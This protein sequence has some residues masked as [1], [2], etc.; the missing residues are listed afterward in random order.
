[1]G[2]FAKMQAET[3]VSRQNLLA[4]PLIGKA[5]KGQISL[6]EY[7]AFLIE[8][9]HH[10]KHTVPLLMAAGARLPESYEWLREAVAE[11]IEEELGHQEWILNDIAA[12]GG[13]KEA[14]RKSQPSIATELMVAYAYDTVMRRSPLGFF[15]MVHVLEGTSITT[16]DA[17]AEAIQ[18]T[19][20]LPSQAFSYLKS[21]GA[22]DQQHVKFFEDLMNRIT[23]PVDQ[24][25]I[26]HSAKVFY[27]LYG[28]IFR[29][30]TIYEKV[31]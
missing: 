21:H 10:V 5:M 20:K 4:A 8:A 23:D 31:A 6:D 28:N 15:G 30:L 19:L 17:A 25:Q 22:L 24:E 7:I 27:H 13:D 2:F 14:V 26:V 1:M 29:S 12:C 11:Y 18:N 9:Y 16:A 3:A